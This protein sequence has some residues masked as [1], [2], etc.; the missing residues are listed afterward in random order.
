VTV[1]PRRPRAVSTRRLALAPVLGLACGRIGFDPAVLDGRDSAVLPDTALVPDTASPSNLVFVTSTEQPPSSLG[2]L[3]GADAL[4]AT[5]AAAAGLPGT[6]VAWLSTSTADAR[7]RLGSARG[8]RRVDGRA[9]A[10]TAADVAT[11]AIYFPPRLDETGA[12]VYVGGASAPAV[13]TGTVA[14]G[15]W[16]GANLDC[17]G[18]TGGGDAAYGTAE[19][20]GGGFS[21]MYFAA[22]TCSMPS[23][24]YCF[25]IDRTTPVSGPTASG[26]RAFVAPN[27]SSGG[28]LA[29]ADARCTADAL[30]AGLPG[31]FRALVANVGSTAISRFDTTAPSWVRVDGVPIAETAAAVATADLIAALHLTAAGVDAGIYATAFTGAPRPNMAGTPNSTCDGWTS[32]SAAQ[33]ASFGNAA[34]SGRSWFSVM[35]TTACDRPHGL[36]CLQE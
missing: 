25:G 27:W 34:F 1:A 35:P 13:A 10:D 14:G 4:C 3:A 12:D 22:N 11:G 36:Y 28:G 24:I 21:T 2:G 7:D 19:A 5:R 30:A 15:I 9:F 16:A 8:W 17:T 23:R 29:A 26:R 31:T 33:T 20:G 6:Y 18:W 32:T